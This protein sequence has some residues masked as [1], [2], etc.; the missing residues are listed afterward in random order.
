MVFNEWISILIVMTEKDELDSL[1]DRWQDI[2]A[3]DPLIKH[4]V[5]TRI[6]AGDSR[7]LKFTERLTACLRLLSKPV[8]AA[9]FVTASIICGLLVA[10]LRV[11][12]VKNLQASE[13]AQN[14]FQLIDSRTHSLK[15][16]DLQ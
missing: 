3:T 2:P 5:W 6:A 4:R 1:L 16:E 12:R 9:V 15:S 8:A 14:Y 10:E 11:S 7:G 13:L